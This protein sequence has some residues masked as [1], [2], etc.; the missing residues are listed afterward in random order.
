MS[1]IITTGRKSGLAIAGVLV[2]LVAV[3]ATI[4]SSQSAA[5]AAVPAVQS[6]VEQTAVVS[7]TILGGGTV[8]TS[9]I[10]NVG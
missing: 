3:V 9:G 7:S 5:D 4:V 6:S 2:L 8:S 1:A 10:G